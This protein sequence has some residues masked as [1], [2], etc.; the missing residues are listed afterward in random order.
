MRLR[1]INIYFPAITV[2]GLRSIFNKLYNAYFSREPSA[3]P[4]FGYYMASSRV[5]YRSHR[6]GPA[7]EVLGADVKSF[8]KV[9][10]QGAGSQYAKDGCQVYF[11]GSLIKGAD[12]ETFVRLHSFFSRDAR[13]VYFNGAKLS[14]DPDHF[15]FVDDWV[16]KDR[17]HVYRGGLIISDDPQ[18]FKFIRTLD[19]VTYY[20]DKMG[21]LAN[22]TRLPGAHAPS[23][24]AMRFGYSRDAER[25]Y[26][27]EGGRVRVLAGAQPAGFHVF[28]A[29]YSHD[30][31]QVF[32]RGK[33]L[34]GADPASFSMLNEE[35]NFDQLPCFEV[36]LSSMN[37]SGIPAGKVLRQ[38]Q[39]KRIVFG[40]N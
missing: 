5:Y 19:E 22:G 36:F 27:L 7:F 37:A 39:V 12:P 23:F 33:A 15:V 18:N 28:N 3:R 2:M 24:H 4:S 38:K 26:K 30:R 34:P 40:L 35:E 17:Q 21:I 31:E 20:R 13:F 14:Q 6:N 10:G 9:I 11:N 1:I 29:Y 25:V 32:W 8:E 16:Q